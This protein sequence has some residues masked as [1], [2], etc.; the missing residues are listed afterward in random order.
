M[1]EFREIK[2]S[3]IKDNIFEM[4]GKQWMLVTAGNRDKFNTMTASWGGAGILWNK[5]VAFSFVRPQRYTFEFMEKFERYTLSFYEEGYRDALN[6]CG[7]ISGR[8]TDKVSQAGLTPVI[9]NSAV[10]FDEA[11]LVLVCRKLYTQDIRPESFVD[12]ELLKNYPENDYHRIYV[13]EIEK[14]LAK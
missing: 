2:P 1:A 14:V 13:G 8:D 4:V 5:P 12:K 9:E 7:T 6:L 10:Y 3:D 11:K